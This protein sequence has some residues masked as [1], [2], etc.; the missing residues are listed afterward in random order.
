MNL[1]ICDVAGN[2]SWSLNYIF[3]VIVYLKRIPTTILQNYTMTSSVQHFFFKEEFQ[4]YNGVIVI[5]KLHK[6]ALEM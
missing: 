5:N 6:N 2:E 1:S 4:R 3:A